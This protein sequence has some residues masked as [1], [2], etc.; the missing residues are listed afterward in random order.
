MTRSPKKTRLDMLLLERGLVDSR[1]QG[2]RL[3]MAGEV[4][5]GGEIVTKPGQHVAADASIRLKEKP[6][7]VSR[8]GE[9]L[10]AALGRFQIEV[11][12]RVCAD[13]GASTGGFTDCLLQAGAARVYAIDVGYGQLAWTL[14]QDERVVVMERVNARYL[15]SLPEP[16]DL[17]CTD[18]SFIS[19]TLLLPVFRG[20]LKPSAEL[21][22]LVKPQFE[23]GPHDVGKGGVVRDPLVHRRVLG[24][25]ITGAAAAGYG[26]LGLMPS[27]LR[28][29]KGNIEFLLW[30]SGSPPSA[31]VSAEALIMAAVDEAHAADRRVDAEAL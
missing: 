18:V 16:I 14:R 6:R 20:W 9:K 17:L 27:P 1:E 19:L 3:I 4:L 8:G 12:G 28:G 25:V 29:P 24:E 26:L 10:A 5:V 2:R 22:L 7:F 11:A 23:A 15:D 13:V 31:V 21:V 30:L